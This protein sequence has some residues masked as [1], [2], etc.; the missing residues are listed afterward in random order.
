MDIPIRAIAG[1]SDVGKALL[2]RR[3]VHRRVKRFAITDS[4]AFSGGGV[5]EEQ[6]IKLRAT[7]IPTEDDLITLPT[8]WN[9]NRGDWLT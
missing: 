4:P 2:I 1:G 9:R 7:L 5:K 6:L 3:R 8:L